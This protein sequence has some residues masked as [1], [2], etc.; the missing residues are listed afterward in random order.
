MVEI[1]ALVTATGKFEPYY[2]FFVS[3]AMP[4]PSLALR[5]GMQAAAKKRFFEADGLSLEHVSHY[6]K[7]EL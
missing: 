2:Y 1:F 4:I 7:L 6:K 3:T 5:A